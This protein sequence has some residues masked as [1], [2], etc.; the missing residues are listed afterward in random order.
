MFV[1]DLVQEAS[2]TTGA[3]NFTTTAVNGRRTFSTVF[4]TGATTNVF[5]YYIMSRDAAEWEQ[6]LG[7]MSAVGTLV[8]DTIIASSNA[9]A[10]V[11]FSAGNKDIVN[12]MSAAQQ[13]DA[14]FGGVGS[15]YAAASFY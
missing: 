4:G 3:G 15:L 12:D 14:S 10:I 8:R 1:G 9:N 13:Q 2:T 6:G 5:R 7:H 11:T